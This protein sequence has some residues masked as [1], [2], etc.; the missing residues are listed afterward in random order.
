M[1]RDDLTPRVVEWPRAGSGFWY[2]IRDAYTDLPGFVV[3]L[4]RG[5]GP[6]PDARRADAERWHRHHARGTDVTHE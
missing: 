1:T 3:S 5:A 6:T 2:V 4:Y